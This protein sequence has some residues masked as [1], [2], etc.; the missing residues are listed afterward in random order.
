[1]KLKITDI[2]IDLLIFD[3]NNKYLIVVCLSETVTD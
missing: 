3:F 2:C 1:M